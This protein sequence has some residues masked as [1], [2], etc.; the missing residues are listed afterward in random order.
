MAPLC[1]PRRPGK[2]HHVLRVSLVVVLNLSQRHLIS[3]Q[4]RS[5]TGPASKAHGTARIYKALAAEAPTRDPRASEKVSVHRRLAS[6]HHK[7]IQETIQDRTGPM[8][9]PNITHIISHCS[10]SKRQTV[11]L[12]FQGRSCCCVSRSHKG[13][14]PVQKILVPF[15]P[16]TCCSLPFSCFHMR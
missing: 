14:D 8:N 6:C 10:S 16:A 3:R 11:C 1:T 5:L 13:F 12:A 15:H 7:T 4:P 9:V 2:A